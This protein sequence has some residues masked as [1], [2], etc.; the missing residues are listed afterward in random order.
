MPVSRWNQQKSTDK[1]LLIWLQLFQNQSHCEGHL[2]FSLQQGHAPFLTLPSLSQNPTSSY[3]LTLA[4]VVSP[5]CVLPKCIPFTRQQQIQT[6]AII[7][8]VV[9]LGGLENKHK[10]RS[11]F[12]VKEKYNFLPVYRN[13]DFK[14]SSE[15]ILQSGW[16]NFNIKIVL[17]R[18]GNRNMEVYGES[19]FKIFKLLGQT[20]SEA[21]DSFI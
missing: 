16:A 19:T 4:T 21:N 18:G 8:P 7:T 6:A 15:S 2:Q 20:F 5:N 17:K 10:T 11:C 12:L 13:S 9:N 1:Y 3:P 14:D